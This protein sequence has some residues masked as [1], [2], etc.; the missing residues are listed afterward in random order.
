MTGTCLPTPQKNFTKRPSKRGGH[1]NRPN[2]FPSSAVYPQANQCQGS[3]RRWDTSSC[4]HGR[5]PSFLCREDSRSCGVFEDMTGTTLGSRT[6]RSDATA[7]PQETQDRQAARSILQ[8]LDVTQCNRIVHNLHRGEFMI[9]EDHVVEN[10][11]SNGLP[12][13]ASGGCYASGS[14]CLRETRSLCQSTGSR[15]CRP[16]GGCR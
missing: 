8:E 9:T 14:S 13:E 15:S 10:S 16:Q 5:D 7:S 11:K 3:T 2:S 12:S 1:K 4:L 6:T